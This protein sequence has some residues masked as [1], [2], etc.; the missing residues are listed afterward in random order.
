MRNIKDIL[1]DIL[2]TIY[3]RDMRQSIHDGIQAGYQL[4]L[5]AKELMESTSDDVDNAIDRINATD[6]DIKA[7]ARAVQDAAN[8]ANAIAADLTARRDAG[9][10]KG[11]K[12]DTGEDGD[13]GPQG[14]QGEPGRIGNTGPQG[15][16]G[17]DGK[18]GKDGEQGPPG[19][20]GVVAPVSGMF[21]LSGDPEGNLWAYYA[22]GSTPPA[23]EIDAGGNIYYITP[24]E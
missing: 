1:Y 12:G 10:F 24:D 16:P 3:G 20:S 5:E 7:Q 8:A 13:T 23:F 6:R 19:E 15:P 14:I 18:D 2:H 22:D 11:Q 9:E 17:K 21:T 4:S